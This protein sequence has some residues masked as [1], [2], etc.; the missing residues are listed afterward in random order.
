MKNIILFS[1]AIIV[2]YVENICSSELNNPNI[3]TIEVIQPVESNNAG[4][5]YIPIKNSSSFEDIWKVE[6]FTIAIEKKVCS[7]ILDYTGNTS[8]PGIAINISEAIAKF[9]STIDVNKDIYFKNCPFLYEILFPS[10][11]QSPIKNTNNNGSPRSTSPINSRRASGSGSSFY[12]QFS[13][14]PQEKTKECVLKNEEQKKLFINIIAYCILNLNPQML[15]ELYEKVTQL[16]RKNEIKLK[17]M[18]DAYN[19]LTQNHNTLTEEYKKKLALIEQLESRTQKVSSK[20]DLIDEKNN[21]DLNNAHA[22][23]KQ[24]SEDL[25]QNNNRLSIYRLISG[26]SFSTTLILLLYLLYNNNLLSEAY[27]HIID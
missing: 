25:R 5:L 9:K 13:A 11:N 17:N 1:L 26:I 24:L 7:S 22:Q 19:V 20:P 2:F 18:T 10:K 12:N 16:L 23:I 21:N 6:L 27:P 15:N 4:V 3:P 8:E 14:D